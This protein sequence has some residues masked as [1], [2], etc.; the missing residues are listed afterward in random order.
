MKSFTGSGNVCDHCTVI[1]YSPCT[2]LHLSAALCGLFRMIPHQLFQQTTIVASLVRHAT[3]G[4]RTTKVHSARCKR[5]CKFWIQMPQ[6]RG[7]AGSRIG[8][9]LQQCFHHQP[10]SFTHNSIPTNKPSSVLNSVRLCPVPT[11][12]IPNLQSRQ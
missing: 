7:A 1:S 11:L 2:C 10:D 5:A 4:L 8:M 3:F 12:P 6:P 9:L